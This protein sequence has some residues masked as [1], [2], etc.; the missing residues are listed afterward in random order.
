MTLRLITII[1]LLCLAGCSTIEAKDLGYPISK[2]EAILRAVDYMYSIGWDDRVS[3]HP[4]AR[5]TAREP[6][7]WCVFFKTNY[8]VCLDAHT[9]KINE[10]TMY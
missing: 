10:V 9:G 1:L 8:V 4:K 5:L 7:E 3:D 2:Q 6:V